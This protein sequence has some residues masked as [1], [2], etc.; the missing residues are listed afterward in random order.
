MT[1]RWLFTMEPIHLVLVWSDDFKNICLMR[2]SNMQVLI[3]ENAEKVQLEKSGHNGN[4]MFRRILMLRTNMLIFFSIQNNF[5]I[6]AI[7]W[8]THKYVNTSGSQMTSPEV[9]YIQ[10]GHKAHKQYLVQHQPYNVFSGRIES[11][12][13]YLTKIT[14][15]VGGGVV[16]KK[17]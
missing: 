1:H 11:T 8:S 14:L 16:R 2:H 3:K 6:I 15:V 17:K 4:I 7:L 12:T 9:K 13:N 5:Y 10:K